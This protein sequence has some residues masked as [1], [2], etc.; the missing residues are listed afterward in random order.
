MNNSSTERFTVT[1]NAQNTFQTFS[2]KGTSLPSLPMPAGA[3]MVGWDV[4]AS[5]R[6]GQW[7]TA[8]GSSQSRNI[9]QEYIV[10]RINSLT[11]YGKCRASDRR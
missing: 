11:V 6:G 3:P 2:G 10:S 1:T 9:S 7:L 4:E 5:G 8:G